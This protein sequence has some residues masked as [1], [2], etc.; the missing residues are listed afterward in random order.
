MYLTT[1]SLVPCPEPTCDAPAEVTDR[2][3]LDSTSGP[4]EHVRTHCLRKHLFLMPTPAGYP[5]PTVL[6]AR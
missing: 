2:T 1:L 6:A 3:T 4:V 5:V